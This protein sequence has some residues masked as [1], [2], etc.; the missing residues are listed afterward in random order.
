MASLIEIVNL[1]HEGGTDAQILTYVRENPENFTEEVGGPLR[2]S[3]LQ[4]IV[5]QGNVPLLKQII[6]I[7]G[8]HFNLHIKSSDNKTLRTIVE[9]AREGADVAK[10]GRLD[11]MSTYLNFLDEWDNFCEIA[12]NKLWETD[13]TI[14]DAET[15]KLWAW[16]RR[17]AAHCYKAPPSRK[18]S[19]GMQVVFT[20]IIE[21]L[22]Q[23]LRICPQQRRGANIWTQPGN[24]FM[25]M[26]DV[27]ELDEVREVFPDMY[28][29][30][31]RRAG[32]AGAPVR[33]ISVPEAI[34]EQQKAATPRDEPEPAATAVDP[35]ATI[36]PEW[37]AVQPVAVSR[38]PGVCTIL[39]GDEQPLFAPS[40]D[41][42]HS[43][44]REGLSGYLRSALHTGPFPVHCPGCM[45]TGPDRGIITRRSL[46]GLVAEGIL[47]ETEGLRLLLQQVRSIPYEPNLD[48]QYAMSKPCPF[49]ATPIAHYK[50]HGCHHI[51]PGGG[52]PGCNKHFCYSCLGYRGTGDTWQGCPNGC[53]LFCHEGCDCPICPDCRP[54]ESCGM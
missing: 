52:C 53:E 27:A 12:K 3:L 35:L 19:I 20:G 40:M 11:S 44:G 9:E 54:G 30:V 49:C 37:E 8:I 17:N 26:M 14:R 6:A 46:K 50:N 2:L 13:Q 29:M 39:V 38:P 47:D 24:D 42:S 4:N 15:T 25:T 45:A 48:L 36:R 43:F 7:P 5:R 1:I 28:E 32:V 31:T 18:W 23:L 41:C 51:K 10:I 33:D 22:G 21:Y 16:L 34:H